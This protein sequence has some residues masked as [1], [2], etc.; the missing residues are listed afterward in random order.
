MTTPRAGSRLEAEARRAA[1]ANLRA[2]AW[3]ADR[4]HFRLPPDYWSWSAEKQKTWA[5]EATKAA[6]EK[7]KPSPKR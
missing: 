2:N 1:E 6:A 3:V 7:L 5:K 4:V